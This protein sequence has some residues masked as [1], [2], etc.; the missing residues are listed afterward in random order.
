MEWCAKRTLLQ[1]CHW[2]RATMSIEGVKSAKIDIEQ[3][4]WRYVC[5]QDVGGA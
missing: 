1:N 5:S 3:E 4:S 2:L